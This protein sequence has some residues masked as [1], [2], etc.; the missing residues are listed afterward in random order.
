M[1]PESISMDEAILLRQVRELLAPYNTE[2]KRMFGSLAFMVGGKICVTVRPER[3]LCHL[4]EADCSQALSEPGVAPMERNGR[5]LKG[6][7]FVD[8]KQLTP[9]RVTAFVG[10]AVAR[11]G[12]KSAL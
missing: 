4:T 9:E 12:V 10:K 6:Y 2:E 7:V 8:A 1:A 5:P 3:M 11:S